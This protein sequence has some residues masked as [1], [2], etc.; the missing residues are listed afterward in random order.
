[1]RRLV[2]SGL[3]MI[4]SVASLAAAEVKPDITYLAPQVLEK[5]SVASGDS[6]R[7]PDATQPCYANDNDFLS[8]RRSLLAIQDVLVTNTYQN[9]NQAGNG[10]VGLT[11]DSQVTQRPSNFVDLSYTS[12][13]F[14][15]S[16]PYASNAAG[17]RLFNPVKAVGVS[18]VFGID[19]VAKLAIRAITD[20]GASE[21][22]Y[23]I[24]D[25][26]NYDDPSLGE[27]FSSVSAPF[28][29]TDYDQVVYGANSYVSVLAAASPGETTKGLTHGA[30]SFVPGALKQKIMGMAVGY[31]GSTTRGRQVVTLSAGYSVATSNHTLTLSYFAVNQDLS[32]TLQRQNAVD[33]GQNTLLGASIAAGHFTSQSFDQLVVAFINKNG[34][35][36]L[37][38]IDF[39]SNGNEILR[40]RQ[41]LATTGRQHVRLRTGHFNPAS[42][43]DQ[44]LMVNW[45]PSQYSEMTEILAFDPNTFVGKAMFS[46][47]KQNFCTYD[48]QT[49]SFDR[50]NNGQPVLMQQFAFLYAIKQSSGAC[51]IGEKLGDTALAIFNVDVQPN[52]S[53]FVYHIS[54]TRLSNS[55]PLKQASLAP[56][57][58]QGRSL[59]LGE[60][61]I[62]VLENNLQPTLILAAPPM[63][64]DAIGS[65]GKIGSPLQLYN[66]SAAPTGFY[67][68]FA[69]QDTKTNSLVEKESATYSKSFTETASLYL[70]YGLCDEKSPAY[71]CV[72]N[73]NK[74][75]AT[76][77][78]KDASSK[79]NSKIKEVSSNL[80]FDSS[81]GLSDQIMFRQFTVTDYV[82]PILGERN[83][84]PANPNCSENEKVQTN[85]QFAGIDTGS[86]EVVG[87]GSLATWYQP[88]WMPGNVLS[89]PA[90]RCQLQIDTFGSCSSAGQ[91]GGFQE[92]SD[93]IDFS[94]GDTAFT[95]T[96]TWKNSNSS[97]QTLSSD[98]T[99]SYDVSL[100]LAAKVGSGIG[101]SVAGSLGFN[102]ALSDALSRLSTSRVDLAAT[103]GITY[104]KTTSFLSVPF[105][106]SFW[107]YNAEPH[108]FGMTEPTG[109]DDIKAPIF[110]DNPTFP[111]KPNI[112]TFG[113]LR[114]GFVVK[115][116]G[117]MFSTLG[118]GWYT[119][120]PDIGLNQPRHWNPHGIANAE[121][122][123][124]LGSNCI[125]LNTID[126]A[127]P[128]SQ[129]DDFHSLSGL[130]V[131]QPGGSGPQITSFQLQPNTALN[132]IQ[133]Q[134]RVYNFSRSDLLPGE[135]VH[136]RFYAMRLSS[137][138]DTARTSIFLGDAVTD[139]I[140][141]WDPALNDT[142]WRL[143]SI[144]FDATPYAGKDVAF[145]VVVYG[146]R[147]G[148]IAGDLPGHGLTS[149]PPQNIEYSQINGYEETYSNNIG[150][151]HQ[152]FHVFAPAASLAALTTANAS[153]TVGAKAEITAAGSAIAT[154]HIG[155]NNVIGAKVMASDG[156]VT[157]GLSLY[158]YDGDPSDGGVLIGEQEQPFLQ[159][160]VPYEYR[161]SFEPGTEGVH[162]I[163][164]VSGLGT[165]LREV[166]VLKPITV[167]APLAKLPN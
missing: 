107:G 87:E 112:S 139:F 128:F 151:F 118:E 105:N 158:F 123:N 8:G 39:D 111:A 92:L 135:I 157:E 30:V 83:C 52:G 138:A 44:L 28:L 104:Q 55:A 127:N 94:L 82:Y 80:S 37:T 142:N 62:V 71:G 35:E 2:V 25:P 133:L 31:F 93:V 137:G 59:E 48:V 84:P 38:L 24:G 46:E 23:Q 88:P 36:R 67:G 148:K 126:T 160:G 101:L 20:P 66:F 141:R 4:S 70:K 65:D 113:P 150:F 143:L 85:L 164:I 6:E 95:T 49:G 19:R 140:P 165:G 32:L 58:I 60:P 40:S 29:N 167:L 81:L 27:F 34:E 161:A 144:Q 136:A 3:V 124:C 131:T 61:Q 152:I 68:K 130:F 96:N 57:D 72:E 100:S 54:V 63:H 45:S 79:D 102:L 110:Q 64:V 50:L 114:S 1:M 99:F 108:I 75:A 166:V 119:K 26:I 76:Q 134:V 42:P 14:S 91:P 146:E 120:A 122:S 98:R 109:L 156:D 74:F 73:T 18:A 90:N 51:G 154:M 97:A 153:S 16:N 69:V 9:Q 125:S 15:I 41:T 13:M 21:I 145:W 129:R 53:Y 106:S 33:I 56:V 47:V 159:A 103:Q 77:I 43:Y 163:Y 147:S 22:S 12:H 121:K 162:T 7:C 5:A 17:A 155:E 116:T 10:Q 78:F 117:G 115:P 11:K 132:K 86:R 89:Y 149:I